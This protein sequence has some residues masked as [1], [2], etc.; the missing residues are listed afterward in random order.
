M[1]SS[2]SRRLNNY[3]GCVLGGSLISLSA[4]ETQAVRARWELKRGLGMSISK[5]VHDWLAAVEPFLHDHRIRFAVTLH[6]LTSSML[7]LAFGI[8]KAVLGYKR[9]VVAGTTLDWLVGILL[10]LV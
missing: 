7:L 10:T 5:S 2:K 3:Q 9:N 6:R 8:T 4:T 1:P